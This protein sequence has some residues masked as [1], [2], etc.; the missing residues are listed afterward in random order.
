MD[1]L[2]TANG[3]GNTTQPS[4]RWMDTALVRWL[5]RARTVPIGAPAG[6]AAGMTMTYVASAPLTAPDLA[7]PAACDFGDYTLIEQIGR[8]GMGT[9]YRAQQQ[10]LDRQVAIKLLSA[11]AQATRDFVDSLRSEARHAAR[12]Q[13][14]NIVNVFEIGERHGLVYYV[15][16]L[17]EGQSLAERIDHD[18]PMPALEAA[19]LLRTIAEAVDYA[20][21]LGVLHLDLKPGNILL[22]GAG[23]PKITDFGLARRFDRGVGVDNDRVSGTPSYMAPEQV[24]VG[25][26]KLSPATDIWGLGAILY[27][28]VTAHPPFEGPDP[29]SVVDLVATGEVSSP[30]RYQPRLARDLEAIAMR[31]LQRAPADRYSSARALADDLGRF[32]ERRAVSVRPLNVFQRSLRWAGREPKL[33]AA[34]MLAALVLV[35]GLVATLVLRQRAEANAAAARAT[36][37]SARHETAWRLFEERRSYRALPLLATNLQEQESAGEDD[38]A[39]R[40]RQRLRIAQM[41]MPALLDSIETGG[42]IDALALST[43]GRWLAVGMQPDTVALYDRSTLRQRWRVK[44]ALHSAESVDRKL[45][46]LVFTPDG[47]HLLVFKHWTMAMMRPSA[48]RGSFRLALADGRQTQMPDAA[49]LRLESWSDDGRHVMLTDRAGTWLQLFN[50]DSWKPVSPRVRAQLAGFSPSWLI[51]PNLAFVASRNAE[52]NIEILDPRTL[53]PRHV[54]RPEVPDRGYDLGFIAWAASPDGRWLALG[55]RGSAMLLV[56]ARSGKSRLLYDP[57]G[58]TTTWMEFSPDSRHLAASN[59]NGE[60]ILFRVPDPVYYVKPDNGVWGFQF[61]CDVQENCTV[62]LMHLDRV[63]MWS[64]AGGDMASD[65]VMLSPEIVHHAYVPRF[66]S[67]MDMRRRQLV[68]GAE[69]GTVRLWR[70]PSLPLRP[71]LAPVQRET[72][73]QFDGQHLVGVDGLRVQVFDAADGQPRSP[74]MA[75]PQ[76]AGFAAL[77]ADGRTLVA[78]SGAALH[79]FDWR[80]GRLRYPPIAL[81]G[82]PMDLLLSANGRRAVVRWQSPERWPPN[83]QRVQAFDLDSGRPIGPAADM[84]FDKGAILS[85]GQRLLVNDGDGSR[86]HALD[87]LRR[88]L[89]RFPA[90]DAKTQVPLAVE[91]V[92]NGEIVQFLDEGEGPLHG[93]ALRRWSLADGR[94]SAPLAINGYA[95]DLIARSSDGR[96][97]I[98]GTASLL[99]GTGLSAMIDR[100]GRRLAVAKTDTLYLT[101]AQAFSA[102]GRILAQALW[103]GVQLIDADSGTALGPPLVQPVPEP[104]FIAQLAFAPDGRS[105]VAR[106]TLGNWLYWSLAADARRGVMVREEADFLAPVSSQTYRPPSQALRASWRA[107]QHGADATA[108]PRIDAWS[109]LHQRP[110]PPPR[111]D[112]TPPWLLD[113][114]Q[115]QGTALRAMQSSMGSRH[116]RGLGNLCALPVGVQRL[117]GVDYDLRGVVELRASTQGGDQTAATTGR[118]PI[119]GRF[120]GLHVLGAISGTVAAGSEGHAPGRVRFHY[121]DGGSREAPLHLPASGADEATWRDQPQVSLAWQGTLPEVE[122]ASD[123]PAWLYASR[124]DNPD[125]Q[126]ELAAVEVRAMVPVTGGNGLVLAALT[127][128]PAGSAGGLAAAPTPTRL[129]LVQGRGP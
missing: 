118:L 6:R 49:Q 64:F 124:V 93:N 43:D 103:R 75:L 104:N 32:L 11:G 2:D 69:D 129:R 91:D 57:K 25:G 99:V 77:T 82:S 119:T 125:P 95:E 18:G 31:C 54:L 65:G 27:E 116:P 89:H 127:L 79:V 74:R 80:R 36:A 16:P 97:A 21:R 30:R 12:M 63:T 24:Q 121:R 52:G 84:P 55:T 123:S 47:R 15:M 94:P 58:L 87:N 85:D 23:V 39:A 34:L 78:S 61:D 70:I 26:A 106:T 29:Q 88:P 62:L 68:T 44:L 111:L 92:A 48:G 17:I 96:V 3:A 110:A 122:I 128:S 72:P 1:H 120:A 53:Q 28:A 105:L 73:L 40:E 115:R 33:A 46:R 86:V 102:D 60:F 7:D 35:V 51:P 37:W 101:R 45:R 41:T 90:P 81:G 112:S 66:A 114:G 56:D 100:D 113:L 126:R 50:A 59:E 20:H 19:A 67:A 4:R 98:S 5:F 22:D 10:S 71:F 83:L 108:P 8:G 42:A 14:P 117:Q 9:V 38:V 76:P 109:C 13:H 107:R